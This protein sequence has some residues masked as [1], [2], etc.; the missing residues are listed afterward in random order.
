MGRRIA[1]SVYLMRLV[2]WDRTS[3][4]G[5]VA[6]ASCSHASWVHMRDPTARFLT[7]GLLAQSGFQCTPD[8]VGHSKPVSKCAS[9]SWTTLYIS[10]AL[11]AC[12]QAGDGHAQRRPGSGGRAVP[13][14]Q[15]RPEHPRRGRAPKQALPAS[16]AWPAKADVRAVLEAAA[17]ASERAQLAL[18]VR[19]RFGSRP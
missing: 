10:P 3:A 8:M 11:R 19:S 1:T 7:S 12:M 6:G 9:T 2:A 18:D 5:Y 17:A 15:V 14:G 4:H 13:D 16:W